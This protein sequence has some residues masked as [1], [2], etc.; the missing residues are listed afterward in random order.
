VTGDMVLGPVFAA[1]EKL[2][3]AGIGSRLLARGNP[4]RPYRPGDLLGGHRAE[5]PGRLMGD[6]TLKS[7]VHRGGL[8][9]GRGGP[10]GPRGPPPPPRPA[11]APAG[12]GARAT[13]AIPPPPPAAAAAGTPT[14]NLKVIGAGCPASAAAAAAAVIAAAAAAI[15]DAAA[16]C[17]RRRCNAIRIVVRRVILNHKRHGARLPL[18]PWC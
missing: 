14:I 11:P 12:D 1:A 8:D 15:C 4:H 5:P 6:A 16:V 3:E 17:T 18:P 2:A 9:R 13:P 10:P 7:M